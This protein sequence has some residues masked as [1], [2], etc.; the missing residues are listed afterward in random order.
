MGSSVEP[1]FPNIVVRPCSRSIVNVASRTVVMGLLLAAFALGRV[2]E[3]YPDARDPDA[4]D[5][6]H[7]QPGAVDPDLVARRRAAPEAVEHQ[8]G[9][10]ARAV[11]RELRPELLVEVVDGHRARDLHGVV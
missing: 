2:R 10:R 8:P 6:G 3:A 7:P 1:G 9:H 4:A 11:L 5:L